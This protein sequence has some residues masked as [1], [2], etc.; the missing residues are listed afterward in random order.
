[1]N[2]RIR[3]LYIQVSNEQANGTEWAIGGLEN[4]NRFAEL[5]VQE[6]LGDFKERIATRYQGSD[7][8]RDIAYGMEIV[9]FSI[10]DKFG[11]DE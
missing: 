7:K 2:E 1:M 5:I 3:E 9:Y 6:C 4:T 8:D 11:V 10:I